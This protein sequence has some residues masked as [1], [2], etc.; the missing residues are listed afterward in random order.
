MPT[1]EELF[2]QLNGGQRFSKLDLSSAYQQVLLDDESRQYVTI[3]TH[4]GLFRYIHGP[5]QRLYA[6]CQ[7]KLDSLWRKVKK[8]LTFFFS[9]SKMGRHQV[10]LTK[11]LAN[12]DH[13]L[14]LNVLIIMKIQT[15]N[16][17]LSMF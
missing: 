3:N 9:T 15:L 14:H 8:A 12:V 16:E 10:L 13:S 7:Q 6:P 4:L 11:T 1:A 2:T 17:Q 5:I